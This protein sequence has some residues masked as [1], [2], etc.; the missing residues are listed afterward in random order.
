MEVPIIRIG[1]SKGIRL[2][3]TMIERYQLKDKVEIVMREGDLLLRPVHSARKDW[4]H[5][6]IKMHRQGEDRLLMGDLFEEDDLGD[7]E[8]PGDI[9]DPGDGEDPEKWK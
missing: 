5:Q 6:F 9:K 8:Y 4:E 1:N 2:S 3:K 7:E